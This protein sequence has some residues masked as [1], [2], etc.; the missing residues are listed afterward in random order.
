MNADERKAFGQWL[1]WQRIDCGMSVRELAE[2]L[3][4]D[5]TT[6]YNVERGVHLPRMGTL[7]QW[8]AFV[9]ID[10]LKRLGVTPP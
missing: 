1:R 3:E 8:L 5:V 9:G 2:L 6:I 10:L 4:V 7:H